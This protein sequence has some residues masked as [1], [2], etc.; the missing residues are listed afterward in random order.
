VLIDT[1]CHLDFDSFDADR[2]SVLAR[3]KETGV[4]RII[5]PA[6]SLENSRSVVQLAERHEEVVAAV[7]VHPNSSADWEERWIAEL[8][9]LADHALVVAIGEIGL[10]YY[11]DRA[12]RS[13]QRR[14]FS[15]QLELAAESNLPIIVHNR[16]SDDDVL[17]LLAASPLKGADRPGVLHSFSGSWQTAEMALSL[18]FYLGFTG[19]IT[20]KKADMLRSVAARVPIDRILVETDAPFLAPQQQRGKR[21]EPAY[22][23]LVAERIAALHGLPVEEFAAQTMANATHLFGKAVAC[24]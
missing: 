2:E 24:G 13:V 11:R 15:A 12:P 22:V 3:A 23:Y 16:E 18:G 17:R 8:R 1:H 4:C 9:T 21:N 6:I 7:G 14:A 10:D 5:V 20:Y 19:P